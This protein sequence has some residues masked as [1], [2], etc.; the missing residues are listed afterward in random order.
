VDEREERDHRERGV[1]QRGEEEEPDEAG[2]EHA[3]RHE[4]LFVHEEVGGDRG[5]RVEGF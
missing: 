5:H 3:G 1:A 2:R 4:G